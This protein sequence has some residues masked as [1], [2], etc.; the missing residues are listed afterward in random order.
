MVAGRE[1]TETVHTFNKSPSTFRLI[2][3][4]DV[5]TQRTL[6]LV[7]RRWQHENGTPGT[8]SGYGK[9]ICHGIRMTSRVEGDRRAE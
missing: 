6:P 5:E 4:R 8:R 2:F 1:T 7:L 9:R 3:V